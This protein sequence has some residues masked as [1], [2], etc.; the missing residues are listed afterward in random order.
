MDAGNGGVW[1]FYYIQGEDGEDRSHPNAFKIPAPKDEA[2]GLTLGDVLRH[3][4]LPNA[5]ATF[6]FRFRLNAS[7]TSNG[8]TK[9]APTFYWLDITAPTQKVPLTNGRVIC[10]LLRLARPAKIGLIL[11]RKPVVTCA[12]DGKASSRHGSGSLD[13]SKGSVQPL[14]RGQQGVSGDSSKATPFH[15][16]TSSPAFEN[17]RPTKYSDSSSG[18]RHS[19]VNENKSGGSSRTGSGSQAEPATAAAAPAQ[20]FLSGGGA[21]PKKA[22]DLM[23]DSSWSDSAAPAPKQNDFLSSMDPLAQTSSVSR[24]SASR[25]QAAAAPREQPKF[26]DDAGQTVGPVTMAEMK[27]HMSSTSDGTNVYNPNLVDKSSKSADVRR[28]MEER[29]RQVRADVAKAREELRQREE[30]TRNMT[31]MKENANA[32]LGPK[33]KAWAEDNGRVKNIRTLLSTMHQ[34][35]WEG[36]KWSEVNMGKLITPPDV[37]KNYRKAMIVVHPDKSGGRNAEQ[38]LIAERVFAAVN[39]AWEEFVKANPC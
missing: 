12:N 30:A 18:S 1:A 6:H 3:F 4:P 26:E 31:A 19:S 9:T 8:G 24:G 28:A 32:V 15:R 10:K 29:E 5:A 36:S 27:S 13:N 33:L 16:S 7:G 35:M 34:V 37:K 17:G 38:L 21:Q 23:S 11:K 2:A 14:S 22:V 39:T 20:D 25:P